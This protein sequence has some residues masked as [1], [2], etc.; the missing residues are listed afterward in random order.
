MIDINLKILLLELKNEVY[1]TSLSEKIFAQKTYRQIVR[2]FSKIGIALKENCDAD[3][4]KENIISIVSEELEAMLNHNP[5]LVAQLFY[6]IDLPEEKIK[7]TIEEG[8]SVVVN[9]AEAILYRSAQKVYLRER[10]SV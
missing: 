1:I 6:S 5:Q 9:I 3:I 4:T 10:F 2:E 8:E 7:K